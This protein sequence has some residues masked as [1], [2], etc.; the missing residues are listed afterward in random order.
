MLVIRGT[1]EL[2]YMWKTLTPKYLRDTSILLCDASSGE[3]V[4]LS[5]GDHHPGN[6]FENDRI[7]RY[8][9]Y[10]MTDSW[11]DDRK[12]NFTN[13]PKNVGLSVFQKPY[14]LDIRNF[15]YTC[16]Q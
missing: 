2:S 3:V 14:T 10:V 6:S 1:T 5:T 16:Y 4:S 15:G 9:G 13:D 7:R 11:G 12:S 8:A